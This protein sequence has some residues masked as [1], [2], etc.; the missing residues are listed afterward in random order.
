MRLAPTCIL[1]TA[2]LAPA[3]GQAQ[4][5]G[6]QTAPSQEDRAAAIDLF[7]KSREAYQAGQFKTAADL[8]R[9]AYALDPA[10][11][12]LYNLARALE[13]DGDLDGAVDAYRRYLVADPNAK[14]RPA[15]EQRISNLDAQLHERA[16]L[17]RRL[18]E[19]QASNAQKPPAPAVVIQ[20]AEPAPAASPVPWILAGAGGAGLIAAGV[21]GGLAKSRAD[22][23]EAAPNQ[24]EAVRLHDEAGGLARGANIAFIAGGAVAGA[25]L[26]WGIIQLVSGD[27]APEP[28]SLMPQLGPNH[29]ALSGRF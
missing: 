23:A 19:Q 22:Q 11:T 16:E 17:E 9:R 14:D 4:P 18:R 27:E 10:P 26:V 12:L 29:L 13:S 3:A 24:S 7:G 6:P 5:R 2:L 21:L 28:T 20:P 25:G 15:I 8:L 1:L